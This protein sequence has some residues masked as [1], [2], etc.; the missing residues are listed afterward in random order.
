MP[1]MTPEQW[2][3]QA[4]LVRGRRPLCASAMCVDVVRNLDDDGVLVRSTIHPDT[5]VAFTDDEWSSF[6]AAVK[7]GDWDLTLKPVITFTG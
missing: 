2:D 7:A 3:R 5:V 6:M 1:N 4:A